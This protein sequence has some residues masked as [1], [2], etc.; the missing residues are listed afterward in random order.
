MPTSTSTTPPPTISS[1]RNPRPAIRS[2]QPR[3]CIPQVQ[4]HAACLG[5]VRKPLALSTTGKPIRSAC[6]R[7]RRRAAC[8]GRAARDG[9]P[10]GQEAPSPPLRSEGRGA[11]RVRPRNQHRPVR[12][13]P[14]RA[15][16]PPRSPQAR[17]PPRRAARSRAPPVPPPRPPASSRAASQDRHGSPVAPSHRAGV[18]HRAPRPRRRSDRAGKIERPRRRGTGRPCII[19]VKDLRDG[20]PVAP[21]EGVVVQRI[22]QRDLPAQAPRAG[23]FAATRPSGGNDNARPA[24][25]PPSGPPHRR[26]R[27]STPIRPEASGP[28]TCSSFSASS[29]SAQ[30]ARPAPCPAA[31]DSARAPA[32]LPASAPVCDRAAVRACSDAPDF[33]ATIRLPSARARAAIASNARRSPIPSICRPSAVT[34]SSSS[35][36]SATSGIPGLRL[37]AHGHDIGQRQAARLHRQVQRDVRGLRDQATPRS[38]RHRAVDVGPERRTVE[39]VEKPVAV[40]ARG[41]A[42]RPPPPPARPPAPS[43]SPVSRTDS[44]SQRRN[45]P[46]RPRPSP[47]S[48][49]TASIVTLRFTPMKAASGAS[50]NASTD[51]RRAARHRRARRMH[52]P[53]RPGKTRSCGIPRSHRR[54]MFRRR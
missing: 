2:A 16:R 46:R 34:R 1:T 10:S 11:D 18:D 44:G 12:P 13:A 19:A 28:A 24:A 33:I 29:I 6:I 14:A 15:V 52:G 54:T 5:L 43:P 37:V 22:G 39:K 41:H 31:R 49:R 8:H 47:D 17:H 3:P 21:D 35:S 20:G 25:C 53:D 38:H 26:N 23:A 50:G 27:T 36:A 7:R 4:R 48:T 9:T 30:R 51:G 42:S 32:S 45:T 40:R